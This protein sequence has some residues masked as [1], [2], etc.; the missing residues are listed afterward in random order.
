MKYYAQF[1]PDAKHNYELV[2]VNDNGE[3][4]SILALNKKTTDNYLHMPECVVNDTNRRLVSIAMIEKANV[5]RFEI[6]P[7]DYKEPRTLNVAPKKGLEEW[8]EGDDKELFLALVEKAKKAREEAHKKVP[9]T[10]LEKAIKARDKWLAK[11][12][13][14]KAQQNA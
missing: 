14:L 6:T 10:E 11:I 7:K 9:M 13:E 2:C 5:E 4:E 8:L 12:E 3:V 1:N